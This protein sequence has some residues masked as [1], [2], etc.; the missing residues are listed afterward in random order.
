MPRVIDS[1]RR[2]A[3]INKFFGGFSPVK[4]QLL[5]EGE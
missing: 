3:R 5:E 1:R 4:T 2:P